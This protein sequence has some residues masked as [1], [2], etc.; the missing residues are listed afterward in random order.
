ME[1]YQI[2]GVVKEDGG[3]RKEDGGRRKEDGGRRKEEGGRRK[4]DMP[5][6]ATGIKFIFEFRHP[7]IRKKTKNSNYKK[8]TKT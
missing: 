2:I 6:P 5:W 8:I 4:P 7:Q 1:D 3:R